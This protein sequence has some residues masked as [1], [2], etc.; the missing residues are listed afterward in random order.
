MQFYK[1]LKE[2]R[3]YSDFQCSDLKKTH[4]IVEQHVVDRITSRRSVIDG[5]IGHFWDF[6][7][8]HRRRH[9]EKVGIYSQLFCLATYYAKLSRSASL[10]ENAL[11]TRRMSETESK[12]QKR[13]SW[14]RSE[15]RKV[16]E[17]F[18]II[19]VFVLSIFTLKGKGILRCYYYEQM[20]R[21][22]V[23]IFQWVKSGI[24][25]KNENLILCVAVN[26]Y[27]AELRSIFFFVTNELSTFLVFTFKY[28]IS[29]LV[30]S[31]RGDL[32]DNMA[33]NV[34]E[35]YSGN[36]L[37]VAVYVFTN[38]TDFTKK[39]TDSWGDGYCLP[40]EVICHLRKHK[41]FRNFHRLVYMHYPYC[42]D[43]TFLLLGAAIL[44]DGEMS[45]SLLKLLQTSGSFVCTISFTLLSV[46]AVYSVQVAKV[47]NILIY[48]FSVFSV[49]SVYSTESCLFRRKSYYIKFCFHTLYE[50]P[51]LHIRTHIRPTIYLYPNIH[52]YF[53]FHPLCIIARVILN[54]HLG[55]LLLILICGD[56]ERN[57]GPVL[58]KKKLIIMTQNC[59][60]LNNPLKLKHII[61]NKNKIVKNDL[62]ILA[63]QET[64]LI[65]ENTTS[66]C[67]RQVFTKAESIHSAGCITFFPETI[68][69]VEKRDIDDNGHGHIA[70]VEG[71]G[72]KLLI[73]VNIYAPVRSLASQ[74]G[75]F[76]EILRQLI[77][78]FETKYIMYEPNLIILGDLNLPLET[79]MSKNM[80]EKARAE[81]LSEYFSSLGLIDCWKQGDS[82]VTLKGGLSRLDRIL[83]RVNGNIKESM[84]IDW[85]FTKSDHGM[86]NLILEDTYPKF[87]SKRIFSLPTFIMNIDEERK[88]IIEGMLEFKSMVDEDWNPHTKLEFLKTG[89]RTVVG[90]VVKLRNKKEKEELEE[91][92]TELERRMVSTKTISLRAMEENMNEVEILF[93]R[94]NN[95]IE[96][97]CE[98]LAVKAKTKWFHEGE[99][100]SK[101][102]LNILRKRNAV[103][104]IS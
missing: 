17:Q 49:T 12:Q 92:Q 43:V 103:T 86:V 23:Y 48:L 93:N 84:T 18:C 62:Y 98:A 72:D 87:K 11:L 37:E 54:R 21:P 19:F 16:K 85:T 47:S 28:S 50:S 56:V 35:V 33:R 14:R 65:D 64:Y 44:I 70:V 22:P 74:Q 78:D 46:T 32:R 83:Y 42:Y 95:I 55:M 58:N 24:I 90:E 8:L 89:L 61:R 94:R 57:P 26:F 2:K 96:S 15:F 79:D 73:V 52:I 9:E 97:K 100:S 36:V 68:R 82:R 101:Y 71:F 99:K 30:T 39:K 81:T 104:E 60:G 7:I 20:G 63:L 13:R 25:E 3:F 31:R 59:R 76:Y 66:W 10:K 75:D 40:E 91:I 67:G 41:H 6:S 51:G 34:F 5:D 45:I 27:S 102:F 80:S 69:I 1:L 29:S 53:Y 4:I 88:K 38:E 77:D